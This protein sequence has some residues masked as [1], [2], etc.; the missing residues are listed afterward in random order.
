MKMH[1]LEGGR[2]RMRRSIYLAGAAK[3][4]SI[5]L[6]V[7]VTLMRHARGNVLFD[8]GCN[9]EAA[10]DPQARW[11]GLSKIMTPIFRP[12]Q[13]VVEQL[14]IVGLQP[15]DIDVVICSHLHPDHCG[16]NSYFRRAT[17]LCHEA[18][19]AAAEAEG[20]ENLGYL[21]TEWEQPQGFQTFH[22][23]H[24]VFGDGRIVVM[25]M[26]GHTPGMSV[27]RVELE[28][29][30]NFVLASDAAPLQSNIETGIAPKNTWD[31]EKAATSLARLKSLRDSGDTIIS[32]HDDRQWQGLKKG[33]ECYE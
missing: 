6:P 15:D 10:I 23:D 30:G 26:P 25:P 1:F 9:P 33:P 3:E 11:G 12:E 14:Q 4:E 28:R 27:A 7:H 29:D 13:C 24:D 20:A 16:C 31:M 18:E 22:A 2:L 17:I 5:E 21:R 19:A 32:G 8:S